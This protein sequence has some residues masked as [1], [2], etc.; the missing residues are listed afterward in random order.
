MSVHIDTSTEHLSDRW[1][2]F[3][4]PY[5][6]IF[7]SIILGAI[8]QIFLKH[9]MAQNGGA[10]EISSFLNLDQIT[11]LFMNKYILLGFFNYGV[12]SLF[13]LA[14]LSKLDVSKAYPFLSLGYVLTALLATYYL[15]E[16]MS[17]Y[18]WMG[19]LMMIIGVYFLFKS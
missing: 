5:L 16:S 18:R 4:S 19:I 8:G 14:V 10:I 17:A 11:S 13:W 6:L 9:G 2:K 1:D 3:M 12:A 15:N 7:I